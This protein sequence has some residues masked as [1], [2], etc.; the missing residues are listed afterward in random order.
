MPA[1]RE[2]PTCD[3]KESHITIRRHKVGTTCEATGAQRSGQP[4]DDEIGEG[5]RLRLKNHSVSQP[6]R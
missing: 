2:H 3:V 5:I 4:M 6:G 1:L